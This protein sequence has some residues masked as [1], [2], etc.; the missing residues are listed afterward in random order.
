MNKRPT[1][2]CFTIG[3]ERRTVDELLDLLKNACVD[4]LV[5]ARLRA[6]TRKPGFSKNSLANR[7]NEEGIRYVHDPRLGTPPEM[8][9]RIK[10]GEGYHDEI[11]KEYRQYLLKEQKDALREVSDLA[12]KQKVC[13]MCYERDYSDCHRRI[14]AEEIASAI[15]IEVTHL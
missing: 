6:N 7:C 15:E 9:E 14:V 8:L 12:G 4:V 11:N 2:S 10:S 3:Y 13:L 5:D 1:R